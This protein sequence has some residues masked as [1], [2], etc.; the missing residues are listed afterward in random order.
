MIGAI[1]DQSRVTWETKCT[2]ICPLN[3]KYIKTIQYDSRNE[4]CLR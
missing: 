2:F 3:L 4:Y 1:I